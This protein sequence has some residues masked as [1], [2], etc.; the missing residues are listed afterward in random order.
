MSNKI[1]E[2]LNQYLSRERSRRDFIQTVSALGLTPLAA[3]SLL[4]YVQEDSSEGI[5]GN[6]VPG[7][8]IEMHEGTG[9]HLVVQQLRAAGIK[10]VIH[11]NT[12]GVEAITDSLIDASDMNI[13][14]VTHEGQ[15]VS[16]AHGYA[17]ATGELAFFIGNPKGV[18]NSISNLYNAW[19]DN[20]PLLI[21]FGAGSPG[22]AP[23][24][25]VTAWSWN[26]TDA[27][28]MPQILRRAMKFAIAPPG[29]PVTLGF[30]RQFLQ[31]KTRAAIH[32]MDPVKS[33]PIFRA[34]SDVIERLARW[35]IEARNPYFLVG[36][37]V[38]RGGA[39]RA[40][41]ALAE[42][43]T[44]PV[45]QAARQEDL[46]SD[47]P[48]DHPLYLGNY[49]S[50]PRF[51]QNV[52]LVVNFGAKF[53]NR[54]RPPEGARV[55]HVSFD[56]E[57]LGATVR[58][59]LPVLSDVST[60]INDL[61]DAIDSLVTNDRLD[62]IRASRMGQINAFKGLIQ[63]SRQMALQ[64][65]FDQKPLSWERVG[66][67]LEKALDKDAVI[68]PELGTQQDKLLS[69]MKFGPDNKL[70]LGRTTGGTLGWGVGAALGAQLGLPDRQVVNLLG[71]GGFLFGQTETLWSI[72]RYEAPLLMVVMNNHSYN[73]TRNRNLGRGGV[74]FQREKDLTSYLG[75]P[76]VDFTKIAAAY[77]IP[78]EKVQNPQ[79]LGPALQRATQQMKE[80]KA[81]LLDVEIAPDGILSNSTWYPRFS[82]AEEGGRQQRS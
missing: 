40:M 21:G 39:N 62:K 24:E 13:I 1:Y 77:G 63:Q 19:S 2:T 42:K 51:P 20:M 56:A 14:M 54:T 50:P 65:R 17:L 36:F 25:P 78:G 37:E 22:L 46:F 71:D 53:R 48:T 59:H 8:T 9:G 31:Q 29:G 72:A 61:A 81:V 79:D 16:V 35:L 11:T 28:T 76:D 4:A 15:A 32:K 75:S 73:E 6:P 57:Q 68:V 30:P 10:Y 45:F 58:T 44:V 67:E 7:E 69:Q 55:V 60:A 18:G 3:N 27:E 66:Y 12:S 64:A 49:I 82:I 34:P 41:Q 43:L 26:C 74:Q 80:G 23:S 47:F 5:R 52:D 38:S 70:K 33:R